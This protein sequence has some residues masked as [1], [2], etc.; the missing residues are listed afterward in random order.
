MNPLFALLFA[1]T[2]L[3]ACSSPPPPATHLRMGLETAPAMLDPRFATDAASARV[4]RLLFERLVDFDAQQ[5][6]RPALAT[7]ELL[8]PTRYR[9]HLVDTLKDNPNARQF[10]NGRRL[11]AYDVKATYDFILEP[12]NASPHRGSL[13]GIQNI[14]V[15]NDDS[16]IFELKQADL[17]FPARLVIGII[18]A[19][20]AVNFNQQP[21]GSG[22]LQFVR[23]QNPTQLVLQRRADKQLIEFIEVKDPVVRVLKLLRAEVDVLQNDLPPELVAW[24]AQKNEVLVL[25][26]NGA[27]FSYLGFNLQDVAT[28]KLAVRQA[29]AK[30]I[31]RQDL[32]HYVLGDA[33]QAANALLPPHHWAG[34]PNLTSY[35]YQPEQARQLLAS[36]GYTA[37]K[38]LILNYKTSTN[39][40]RVRLATV[41]QHQLQAVG[42]QVQ[43]RTYDWGTFYA[44]IKAGRF[45]MFSLAWVGIKNPDIFRY[46]LHSQAVPPDGAN[47]GRWQDATTDKLIEQAEQADSL[48][49][50]AEFYRQ[51]QAHLL[52][53]LPYV[54]LWYENQILVARKAVQG[55]VMSN[56][57][58]FDGLKQ[59]WLQK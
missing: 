49:K 32:I 14:I 46:A 17:L 44:D 53:Q 12:R 50:Q 20:V 16:L 52:E 8:S 58:N 56:D 34:N 47:R 26:K 54:P 24:L 36:A 1:L 42:I 55:Y 22:A 5:R 33:A 3:T 23:W 6:P 15:E 35:D 51:L 11:T 25:R 9:F 37:E 43:L 48:E 2:I 39:P 30:G 21:I 19:Q 45:Q 18:P 31:N 41:I 59:A 4:N 27:D 10:S 57:G 38:P 13:Q 7:W 28:G 29:I 40:L